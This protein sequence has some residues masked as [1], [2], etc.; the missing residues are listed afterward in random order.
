MPDGNSGQGSIPGYVAADHQNAGESAII[1][2]TRVLA[3]C[4][5]ST[6]ICQ[7]LNQA[8]FCD[9]VW[10]GNWDDDS[11]VQRLHSLLG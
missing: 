7:T 5:Y 3:N 2:E 6:P 11:T 10:T 1:S 9:R 8:K 4:G